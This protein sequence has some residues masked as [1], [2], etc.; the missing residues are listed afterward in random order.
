MTDE[1]VERPEVVEDEHLVF[2]DEL[3]ESG[4][5]NMFGAGTYLEQEFDI[6][7]H[8]ASKILVYWMKSYP[9]D[10]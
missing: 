4:I 1:M 5:T 2:L 10:R 8:E 3:R 9:G 7:R 6:D